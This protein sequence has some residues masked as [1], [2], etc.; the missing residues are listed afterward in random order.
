MP[1]RYAH[2]VPS[3]PCNL[4]FSPVY[5]RAGRGSHL[6]PAPA[7]P[8]VVRR[9]T[10]G[11]G[12]VGGCKGEH[13]GTRSDGKMAQSVQGSSRSRQDSEDSPRA[14]DHGT[15]SGPVWERSRG[16]RRTLDDMNGASRKR[17]NEM[18]D[19]RDMGHF[20]LPVHAGATANVLFTVFL[21]Y[22]LRGRMEGP[23]VLPSIKVGA[24]LP[25]LVANMRA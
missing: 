14:C 20:P 1:S 18:D 23:L 2:A 15:S 5:S 9:T 10:I 16:A 19:L 3:L 4:A 24:T 25:I 11:E 21:T 12:C 7:W 8:I 17:L 13:A 22:L 6:P